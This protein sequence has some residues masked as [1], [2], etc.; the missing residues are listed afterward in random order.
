MDA[1]A[2]E[3]PTDRTLH[4][5][6]LGELDGPTAGAVDRHLDACAKCRRRVGELSGGSF[7][8]RHRDAHRPDRATDRTASIAAP[9][10]RGPAAVEA[11]TLPAELIDHPDYEIIRELGRGGMGVVYLVR[12]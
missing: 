6:G 1:P 3:H 11:D 4:A 5:Y 7:S 8:G 12:N 10:D 9:R 2:P